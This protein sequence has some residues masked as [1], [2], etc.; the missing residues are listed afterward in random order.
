[1]GFSGSGS[2]VTRPHTHS[3]AIV[4]DGG[5]LNMDNVTQA[6]L[7]AGDIIYSDGNALQRLAF[8]GV[9]AGEALTAA[10][11]TS[12][13]SWGAASASTW[14]VLYDNTLGS[15]GTVSSGTFAAHDVLAVYIF[16][17]LSSSG[18]QA[19]TFNNTGSGSGQIYRNSQL[20]ILVQQ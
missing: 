5:A 1:M 20:K 3:S 6:S 14:T 8:P 15:T 13:P 2:S 17:Q 16:A 18:N 7:T 9:P 10:A 11:A 4:N 19:V 12:A